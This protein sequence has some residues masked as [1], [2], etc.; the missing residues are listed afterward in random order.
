MAKA[1]TS[2]VAV[3]IICG[4]QLVKACNI[5]V[6]NWVIAAII[7]GIPS[8]IPVIRLVIASAILVPNVGNNP[9]NCLINSSIANPLPATAAPTK[10]RPVP[11]ANIPAPINA[12][13]ALNNAIAP[14]NAI[15]VGTTGDNTKPA[16]PITVNAPA[17]ANNPIPTCCKLSELKAINCGVNNANAPAII[18]IAV[19]PNIHPD[20]AYIATPNIVNEP[21]KAE[22]PTANV[23]HDMLPKDCKA[24]LNTNN[25]A[26]IKPIPTATNDN[27]P[28]G[29]K[30]VAVPNMIKAPAIPSNPLPKFSHGIEP[31]LLTAGTK[32]FNAP[33]NIVNPT[34]VDIIPPD[35]VPKYENN[36]N[37]VSIKPIPAKPCFNAS[38]SILP[39][40][41]TANANTFN[42][43]ANINIPAALPNPIL[44][45][46]ISLANATISVI[47]APKPTKPWT[48]VL[49][50]NWP[51]DLIDD[52]NTLIAT[53]NIIIDVAVFIKPFPEPSI[54]LAA[55]DIVAIKVAI[56]IKP[57][58]ISSQ[59]RLDKTFI[60]AESS[61]IAV[62]IPII[63]VDK[64]PILRNPFVIFIFS[65]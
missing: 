10:P 49:G 6:I 44:T 16:T 3:V 61:N 60:D 45:P 54:S 21:A 2:A 50:S 15:N 34:A 11:N 63:P 13:E 58:A 26:D 22:R 57:L 14:A 31:I 36:A 7:W 53:P 27:L 12:H 37:S 43:A 5:P 30:A 56:L 8:A 24:A 4:I 42:A 59:L 55:A 46:S 65:K 62:D 1:I 41:F 25:E 33:A 39:N 47:T 29:I 51:R 40:C 17:N 28:P 52:A 48:N 32:R 23:S 35:A 9:N 19:A 64:A 38:I 20:I 18:T